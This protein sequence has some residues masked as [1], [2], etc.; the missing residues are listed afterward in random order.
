MLFLI[1]VSYLYCKGYNKNYTVVLWKKGFVFFSFSHTNSYNF[2]W[3]RVVYAPWSC[4]SNFLRSVTSCRRCEDVVY[5]LVLAKLI[6]VFRSDPT[7][8]R[9]VF[10]TMYKL[11]GITVWCDR[12]FKKNRWLLTYVHAWNTCVFDTTLSKRAV[13][14]I[15][16]ILNIMWNTDQG[17]RGFRV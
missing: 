8:H 5:T 4:C 11:C 15:R 12:G 1:D 17:V 10:R 7:A 14:R 3:M 16:Y 6:G 9:Q 2:K 13:V